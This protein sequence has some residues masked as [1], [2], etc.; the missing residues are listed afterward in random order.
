MYLLLLGSLRPEEPEEEVTMGRVVVQDNGRVY[1]GMK[2]NI[3]SGISMSSDEESQTD[4]TSGSSP[5]PPPPVSAQ[6]LLEAI[7]QLERNHQ[8]IH[9][10]LILPISNSYIIS[11][12]SIEQC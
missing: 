9:S 1:S 6:D 7:P 4:E 12:S 5:L 8:L 2:R 10:K 3:R 11:G